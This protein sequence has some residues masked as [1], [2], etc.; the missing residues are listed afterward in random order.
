MVKTCVFLCFS[1]E[2]MGHPEIQSECDINLLEPLLPQGVVD[3][4]FSKYVKTFTVRANHIKRERE[5][6][7]RYAKISRLPSL[8]SSCTKET[9]G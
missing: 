5:R 7:S 6:G 9:P 8:S 4:L 1:A 3:D 2:M